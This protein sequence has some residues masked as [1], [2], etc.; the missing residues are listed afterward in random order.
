MRRRIVYR[1]RHRLIS[2]PAKVIQRINQKLNLLRDRNGE[3]SI[4]AGSIACL[5]SLVI[6][7]YRTFLITQQVYR[8]NLLECLGIFP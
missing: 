8:D 6:A 2:V 4:N 1:E 3:R 7:V 5:F